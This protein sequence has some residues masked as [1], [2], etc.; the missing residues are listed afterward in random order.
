MNM[1]VG[2]VRSKV[3]ALLLGPG[4]VG[5]MGALT[6][7]V[8]VART[9]AELGINSSGVRQVAESVTTGDKARVARTVTVLQRVALV[10]GVLGG[11]VLAAFAFPIASMT[12]GDH[13]WAWAVAVLGIAVCFRLVSDAEGALLQGMRRI[14]DIARASVYG[15]VLGTT[16]TVVLVFWLQE[17]G[18]AWAIVSGAAVSFLVLWYYSRQV[19]IERVPVPRHEFLGETRD[20]LQLGLAFMASALLT[21]GASYLVRIILIRTCGLEGAGLYQAAWAIGGVYVNFVLQAMG[22]DF[23]PRLVGVAT[24]NVECNRLVNEQAMV[25]LL[26]SGF[27][28]AATLT[29]APWVLTV[30]YSGKFTAATETLRWVCL[31]MAL[32]VV[33]WPLGYILVAK[34]RRTLFVSADLIWTVLNVALTWLC[35]QRF[36]LRGAGV[37]FFAS[38]VVHALVVYPMCRR[39]SGFRW[40][41]ASAKAAFAFVA[42]I[43]AVQCGFLLMQPAP[44][45]FLGL[46]VSLLSVVASVVALRRLVAPQRVPRKLGWLLGRRE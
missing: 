42:S 38:Y 15:A 9:L 12:F 21:V 8:D 22:T 30:L 6:S 28:V 32:R 31:G 36:G 5:L 27:G 26:L 43:G 13:R 11:G 18:V 16:L 1:L 29:L 20:L 25:S 46:V 41:P 10:L 14:G 2:L 3:M 23:Y 44:A 34:G 7:I 24:D 4:G 33:T 37:A 19:W 17:D 39:V 40:T 45:L 35:V